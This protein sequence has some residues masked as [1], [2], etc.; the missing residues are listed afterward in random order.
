MK[1]TIELP[2]ELVRRAKI[3]AASRGTTMRA[4]V[5]WGL[6]IAIQSPE[7]GQEQG[8]DLIA[9]LQVARNQASVL[10]IRREQI[11]DRHPLR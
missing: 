3:A 2:D 1:T 8:D 5:M 4:L 9:A 7:P 11:Y 6:E 10:P